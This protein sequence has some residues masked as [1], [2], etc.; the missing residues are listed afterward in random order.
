MSSYVLGNL[1][2]RLLIS[3]VIVW[4]IMLL[5]SRTHWRDSF[6]RTHRLCGVMSVATVL[7]LGLISSVV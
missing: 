6:R 3:Y 5:A 4:T 2:G 1:A 7:V